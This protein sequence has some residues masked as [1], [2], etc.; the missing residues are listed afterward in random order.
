VL[1]EQPP[2]KDVPGGRERLCEGVIEVE[3]M[4]VPVIAKGSHA[5]RL[6][7]MP[8]GSGVWLKG[9]LVIQNWN[10]G[11]GTKGTDASRRQRMVLEVGEIIVMAPPY[12]T[13]VTG[14][15]VP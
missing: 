2:I 5:L 6:G 3:D 14:A 15:D 4:D 7:E 12:G 10:T 11:G 13:D 8:A 9:R 1:Q